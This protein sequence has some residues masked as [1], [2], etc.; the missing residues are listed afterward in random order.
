MSISSLQ[1]WLLQLDGF[2]RQY[3]NATAR[4][5]SSQ[6]VLN[7]E[8]DAPDWSYLL[9]CA[10]ILAPRSDGRTQDAALRLAHGCLDDPGSTPEQKATAAAVLHSLLNQPSMELAEKRGVIP[11]NLEEQLP[12]ALQQDWARRRGEAGYSRDQEGTKLLNRFQLEFL[13]GA[14]GNG[15]V[16][17]SAPTSAGK[18]FAL[19]ATL[20]RVYSENPK[21]RIAYL[22]PTRA[23][24]AQVAQDVQ[25]GLQD[26]AAR[27]VVVTLPWVEM[28]ADRPTLF[29]L[30]QER[31]HVLLSRFRDLQLDFIVVDE[32]Q[33]VGDG[34]RGILL[35]QAISAS[36][37]R[38]SSVRVLFAMPLA[39][40]P[41]DLLADG[42]TGQQKVT[43]NRDERTVNQN[44]L[45][46]SQL[47]RQ[48]DRW[49][50]DLIDGERRVN[51]GDFTLPSKPTPD[52]KRLPFVAYALGEHMG[53]NLIYANTA[54]EA[55]K[56]ANLLY[57]TRGESATSDSPEVRE[58]MEL[59]SKIVHPQY[60]LRKVLE[61]GIGFHYGSMPQLI[62][63]SLENL[64][65][66]GKIQYMICTSTLI[67][68]V[69]LACKSIFVRAPSKGRGVPMTEADFWNMGGRAGRWGKE[70]QGN[71]ICVDPE[72][73]KVWKAPVPKSRQRGL[74]VRS[75]DLLVENPDG[76]VNF[77]STS[78]EQSPTTPESPLAYAASFLASSMIDEGGLI[79]A[80]WAARYDRSN[81][82]LLERRVRD[83]L[84]NIGVSHEAIARNPGVDPFGLARLKNSFRLREERGERVAEDW[85]LS[86]P[87]STDMVATYTSALY[88]INRAFGDLF[89]SPKNCAR[90]A[91]LMK[92]W[93]HGAQLPR[94]IQN[95]IEHYPGSK[96]PNTIRECMRDVE[97]YARFRGPKYLKAYNCVLKE[98][99]IES[100]RQDIAA[101]IQDFEFQLELGVSL[102]TQLSLMSIGLSR[103]TAI[104]LSEIIAD[105]EM[106]EA[107]C[108]AWLFTNLWMVESVPLL[109]QRE[110]SELLEMD[111]MN[112]D[113]GGLFVG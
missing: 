51:L 59:I 34:N 18:S 90:L 15:W 99:L 17:V 86:D 77:L 60:S 29:V 49:T 78:E 110:V 70:F 52:S 98:H 104:T 46:A 109:A 36:I 64:F 11:A 20:R 103:S 66:T 30:T 65:R 14:R 4:H 43:V 50:L 10:S 102:K 37:A 80:P 31:L 89:G 72:S 111:S 28:A 32:A 91:L 108:K 26:T 7:K 23:L 92:D 61:R 56:M 47:P 69:N 84:E 107:Q 3:H 67:E 58:L 40:N 55:E 45:W 21:S 19:I 87:G 25:R 95:R 79:N 82:L 24:V 62:R 22:V 2:E 1:E 39:Q 97:E 41:E 100:G 106:S 81:I 33:K 16:A 88:R 27:P 54:A 53:G 76:L 63:Q 112:P 35:Q 96:L 48:S 85:L 113:G 101:E 5:V 83:V 6:F 8:W 13:G 57:N 68:G 71:V 74:I 44:L 93:M 73:P 9:L 38:N 105:S 42:P 94:I 75:L 12:L